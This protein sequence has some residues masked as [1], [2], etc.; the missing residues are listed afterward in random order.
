M[1]KKNISGISKPNPVKINSKSPIKKHYKTAIIIVIIILIFSGSAFGIIKYINW[2][3]ELGQNKTGDK[4][5]TVRI[6]ID[7]E[8][9]EGIKNWKYH[10]T[11][12]DLEKEFSGRGNPFIPY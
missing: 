8:T 1:D 2:K 11:P 12:I 10:G 6:K 9:L 7:T 5:E 4:E 3:T